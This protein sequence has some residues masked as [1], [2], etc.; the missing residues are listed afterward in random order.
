MIRLK[1]IIIATAGVTALAGCAT[2]KSTL[3][4]AQGQTVTCEA[5]GKSGIV[6]GY[7]LRRGF[8]DCI[9]GAKAQGFKEVPPN[10]SQQ[11]Q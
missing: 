5:S 11:P 2:Y 6:T 8:E 7:Y 9:A 1:L 10:Q 3:T 4:N